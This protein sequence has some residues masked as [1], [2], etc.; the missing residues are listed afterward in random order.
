MKPKKPPPAKGLPGWMASY[1]D[2]VTILMVFFILMYSMSIIDEELFAAFIAS[3][4]R[5]SVVVDIGAGGDLM[6]DLGQGLLENQPPPSPTPEPSTPVDGEGEV[7]GELTGLTEGE[8]LAIMENSFMTYMATHA[9]GLIGPPLEDINLPAD[10]A[11]EAQNEQSPIGVDIDEIT[12]ALVITFRD[13]VL[14]ASGSAELT[15]SA[16]ETL[17]IVAPALLQLSNEGHDILV[18]GHTDNVPMNT[19][20]FPSNWHLSA[21]RAVT[22]V[23][24]LVNVHGFETRALRAQG[25]SEYFPIDTNDTPEGRANNRRIEIRVYAGTHML[26][27]GNIVTPPVTDIDDIDTQGV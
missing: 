19:A 5:Q 23:E 7:S 1:A 14:F 4:G 8:I 27:A 9:P 17:G 6:V 10:L 26:G 3:F 16:L 13:G 21:G 12:G 11:G 22:V 15:P 20:R 18:E 25:R 2:M 24:Y